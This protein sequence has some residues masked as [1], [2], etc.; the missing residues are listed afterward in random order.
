MENPEC[1]LDEEVLL[2]ESADNAFSYIVV[3]LHIDC[4]E[5]HLWIS[6]DTTSQQNW[7]IYSQSA[8]SLLQ[9]LPKNLGAS[10]ISL[11]THHCISCSNC[12]SLKAF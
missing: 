3:H 11:C 12:A 1:F 10:I 5:V 8:S 2:F 4:S 6:M 9:L 7:L